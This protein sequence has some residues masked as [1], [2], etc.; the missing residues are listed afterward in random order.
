M[1]RTAHEDAV[2]DL[3]VGVE[4]A[5]G[6][7][8]VDERLARRPPR[9]EGWADCVGDRRNQNLGLAMVQQRGVTAAEHRNSYLG[10]LRNPKEP[11]ETVGTEVDK[12]WVGVR[13]S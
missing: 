10:D 7:V 2:V 11:G 9:G 8:R 1:V 5:F 6:L 3:E 13:A 4:V 12:G